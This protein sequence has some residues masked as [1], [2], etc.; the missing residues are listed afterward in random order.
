MNSENVLVVVRDC[1]EWKHAWPCCGHLTDLGGWPCRFQLRLAR[2]IAAASEQHRSAALQQQGKGSETEP[3]PVDGARPSPRQRL[4]RGGMWRPPLWPAPR[5]GE[6]IDLRPAGE[7]RSPGA[8]AAPAH[9][10][11]RAPCWRCCGCCA[12]PVLRSR[13]RRIQSC[14]VVG[15]GLRHGRPAGPVGPCGSLPFSPTVLRPRRC[16]RERSK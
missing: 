10:L 9:C 15:P 8:A 3:D 14:V 13:R 6:L 2:R 1:A 5:K 16:D 4:V 12:R 11:G 7:K